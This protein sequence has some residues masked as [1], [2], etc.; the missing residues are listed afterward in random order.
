MF[1]CFVKYGFRVSDI[2]N[3]GNKALENE[4]LS[5]TNINAQQ[6]VIVNKMLESMI[7]LDVKGFENILNNYVAD[8]GLEKTVLQLIFPFLDKVGILWLAN[9]VS[10][11][12][13][14]LVSNIIRE[15]IIAAIDKL[16]F[17]KKKDIQICLFLPAGEY[18]E[19]L[20]LFI[21]FQLKKAGIS[22][23][24]LGQNVSIEELKEVVTIKKPAFLYTHI[25]TGGQAF[26]FDVFIDTMKKQFRNIP[27]IISGSYARCYEKKIPL[28]IHLKKSL[29][30]VKE[31]VNDLKN[32]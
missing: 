4:V 18:N 13:E 29:S 12:Q 5:I 22:T 30:E 31:F 19:L 2:N 7:T 32:K 24:Y 27:L 3:M 20:L 6:D 23:I 8:K 16:P 26:S 11:T 28:K 10:L 15:K 9:N 25:S 21:Y 1:R 14:R 17:V